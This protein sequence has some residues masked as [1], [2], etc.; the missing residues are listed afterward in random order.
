MSG[1]LA[2]RELGLGVVNLGLC[3]GDFFIVMVG[4]DELIFRARID[5]SSFVSA[6]ANA[7]FERDNAFNKLRAR[8]MVN[9][10]HH[11]PT[12]TSTWGFS[13]AEKMACL[14]APVVPNAWNQVPGHVVVTYRAPRSYNWLK[15]RTT[16]HQCWRVCL[17]AAKRGL[18]TQSNLGVAALE[19]GLENRSDVP[20]R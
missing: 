10:Y 5:K 12:Q 20:E 7:P 6:G 1:T 11:N 9:I 15:S 8:C 13:R 18:L 19:R 16:L 4:H 14:Q 17:S 3:L 2:V